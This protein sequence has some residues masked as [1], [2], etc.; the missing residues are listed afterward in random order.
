MI[1]IKTCQKINLDI[2]R[3]FHAQ[4]KKCYNKRLPWFARMPIKKGPTTLFTPFLTHDKRNKKCTKITL[5]RE[6][7]WWII[8]MKQLFQNLRF[9]QNWRKHGLLGNQ[10]SFLTTCIYMDVWF[11]LVPFD[12]LLKILIIWKFILF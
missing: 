1:N 7:T 11:N 3:D 6:H 8:F 4:K 12:W 10:N 9:T 5:K 2:A